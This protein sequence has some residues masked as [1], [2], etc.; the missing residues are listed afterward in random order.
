MAFE[1]PEAKRSIDQ[2][3]YKFTISGKTFKVPKVAHLN[4][5]EL[6]QLG[7][8]DNEQVYLLFGAKDSAAYRAVKGLEVET[9]LKPL[10][11]DWAADSELSVG[12][13]E[14]S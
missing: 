11:E 10:L 2:N 9:Q 4:G 3:V 6:E 14:A 5:F 12:E 1:V 13:S 7:S 8:E